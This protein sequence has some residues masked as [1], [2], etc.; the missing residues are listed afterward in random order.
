MWYL[1]LS[2]GGGIRNTL[3]KLANCQLGNKGFRQID[4]IPMG[5]NCV[6]LIADL[7]Y[8]VM[9]LNLWLTS[10]TTCL[11]TNLLVYSIIT[12]H[13]DDI[14]TVNNSN[15]LIFV[16]QMYPKERTMNNTNITTDSCQFSDFHIS[17]FQGNFNTRF[18]DKRDKFSLPIVSFLF[19]DA[20]VPSFGPIIWRLNFPVSSYRVHLA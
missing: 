20:D 17:F 8:T 10:K 5:T 12:L 13:L 15:C 19:L 11:S 16:E 6:P 18:C 7:F 2:R 9:N 4:G 3:R 14:L 1:W